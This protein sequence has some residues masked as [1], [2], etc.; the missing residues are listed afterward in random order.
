M[1]V[2][3]LKPNNLWICD[4][5]RGHG[6]TARC[7][8]IRIHKHFIYHTIL[9]EIFDKLFQHG[10]SLFTSQA[11]ATKDFEFGGASFG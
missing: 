4:D 6:I 3:L 7:L 10:E 5:T 8:S 11:G 2:E 1:H 9:L